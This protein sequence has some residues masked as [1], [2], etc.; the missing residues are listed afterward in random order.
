MFLCRGI[1]K[2]IEYITVK[3]VV[4]SVPFHSIESLLN[5]YAIYPK[6]VLQVAILSI[7]HSAF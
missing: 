4:L 3:M 6:S 5:I 1:G 2:D 7:H